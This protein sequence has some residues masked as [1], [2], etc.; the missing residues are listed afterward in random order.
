MIRTLNLNEAASMLKMHPEEVRR[1]SK[2][3]LIPAAKIGKCWVFLEED[4]E[5]LIRSNYVAPLSFSNKNREIFQ[6][7]STD[8]KRSG[9]S[10]LP[11]QTE[12]EYANLLGLKTKP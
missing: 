12:S 11:P 7:H 9:G 10:I 3:G 2:R 6:C 1:R 8:E 5:E 4:L